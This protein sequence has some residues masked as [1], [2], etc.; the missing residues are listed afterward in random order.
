M[1]RTELEW[2]KS[3]WNEGAT[4]QKARAIARAF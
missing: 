3:G 2:G 1:S 4:K